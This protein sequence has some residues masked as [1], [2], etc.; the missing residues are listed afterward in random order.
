MEK[1]RD[2][3]RRGDGAGPVAFLPRLFGAIASMPSGKVHCALLLMLFFLS[4]LSFYSSAQKSNPSSLRGLSLTVHIGMLHS[5]NSHADF[6]NGAPKN[7][8]TLERILYSETYGNSIW[9]NLTNQ[10]LIGSNIANY[11]QITVAEYGNM[12]YKPAIQ[13]GMGFRYDFDPS[14]WA[15]QIAFDYAKNHAQGIVLLNSGKNNTILSNQNQYVNCPA[16]GVEER[17]YINLG[18]IRKIHLRKGYDLEAVLGA[19][20]N[21]TKVESSDIRIAGV[22]YSILDIWGGLAPSSYVGSYEY[23]NQGGVGFGAWASVRLGFTLPV[24]TAMTID[25]T[26][27]YNKVN[28]TGYRSFALHHALG[29]NVAIN[30]FSFFDN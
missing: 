17:I 7:A 4:P 10:D 24:G 12:Y 25:Y 16:T 15:W 21:N 30:N 3:D 18:I 27:H 20:I 22:T 29:I 14:C 6:Y 11:H 26:L 23:I 13:L 5:D 2:R 9:N 8:N 1:D 28:L 19:N